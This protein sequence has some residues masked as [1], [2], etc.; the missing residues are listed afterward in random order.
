MTGITVRESPFSKE[1]EVRGVATPSPR[2][3]I[4]KLAWVRRE[5]CAAKGS[6][7]SRWPSSRRKCTAS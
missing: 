7:L 2:K 6:A 3:T 1:W 4:E 5:R